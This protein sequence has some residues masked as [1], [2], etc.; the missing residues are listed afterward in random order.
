MEEQQRAGIRLA[1]SWKMAWRIPAF[2]VKTIFGTILLIAI[3]MAY[4]FI[5]NLMAP[6]DSAK[7]VPKPP[8]PDTAKPKKKQEEV[9][10][11]GEIGSPEGDH[12]PKKEDI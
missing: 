3:L 4:H 12:K 10:M 5:S 8:S 9:L 6:K 7:E 1:E 11:P 2:R